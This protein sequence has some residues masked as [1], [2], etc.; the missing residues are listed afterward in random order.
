MLVLK[1]RS[2]MLGIFTA[3]SAIARAAAMIG[4]AG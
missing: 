4:G 3:A 1:T 2:L